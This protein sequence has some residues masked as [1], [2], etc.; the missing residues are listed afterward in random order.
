[1]DGREYHLTANE[2]GNTSRGKR[3]DLPGLAGGK[4]GGR[5]RASVTLR[6]ESPD[7][8]DGFP[9]NLAME[10]TYTLTADNGV[11]IEYRGTTDQKTPVNMTN[12]S[13][14]NLSGDG[15]N[16]FGPYPLDDADYFTAAN[17]AL[18]PTGELA[19]VKVRPSTLPPPR[20]WAGI[21]GRMCRF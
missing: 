17:E 14:F 9:G 8:E 11:R 3:P 19:P 7:G 21:S 20:R 5:R 16:G 4:G 1:M 6:V 18:L 15:E 12:H 10:M 13:F 2:N